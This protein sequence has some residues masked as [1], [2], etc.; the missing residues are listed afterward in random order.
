MF[1]TDSRRANASERS[2]SGFGSSPVAM[3][4]VASIP[5]A[6]SARPAAST[7]SARRTSLS[8][9]TVRRTWS[10][11]SRGL[12]LQH[13]G[14]RAGL[15]GRR[16]D[17]GLDEL[18]ADHHPGELLPEEVVQVA[19]D[20]LP[21]GGGR[22]LLDPDVVDAQPL[23]LPATCRVEAGLQADDPDQ[24]RG[25]QH[26]E[27]AVGQR[28][29]RHQREHRHRQGETHEPPHGTSRR[30]PDRH[31][32]GVDEEDRRP[33]VDHRHHDAEGGRPEQGEPPDPG[34]G[35]E[36]RHVQPGHGRGG[37]PDDGPGGPR[38]PGV[39]ERLPQQVRHP[40]EVHEVAPGVPGRPSCRGSAVGHG[41]LLI[42]RDDGT[43]PS[44]RHRRPRRSPGGRGRG[45]PRRTSA[46]RTAA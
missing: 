40:H 46:P 1:V 39:E 3:S 32:P 22:Q 4:K 15:L 11:R 12:G 43:P 14:L 41:R 25:G 42:V 37:H 8:P 18:A 20:P 21:L 23:G 38:R 9:P 35:V 30:L 17:E 13:P 7:S 5:A 45:R 28:D 6:A 34:G 16:G 44:R 31:H 29:E 24:D 2:T 10:S 36:G 19:R 26:P 27:D 33:D